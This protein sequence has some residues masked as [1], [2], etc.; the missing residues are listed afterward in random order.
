MY[1]DPIILGNLKSCDD[2]DVYSDITVLNLILA[3]YSLQ[4][5]SMFCTWLPKIPC[6]LSLREKVVV[7]FIY[8]YEMRVLVW[9]SAKHVLKQ[10]FLYFHLSL[11]VWRSNCS[12]SHASKMRF[13]FF[14]IL[15]INCIMLKTLNSRYDFLL[16]SFSFPTDNCLKKWFS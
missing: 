9:S 1:C 16:C 6:T 3:Y 4:P 15:G 8:I 14:R 13:I 5:Y 12:A 2:T 10:F 11:I 7:R